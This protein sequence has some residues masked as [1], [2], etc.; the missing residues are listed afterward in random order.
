MQELALHLLDIVQNSI[1][2]GASHIRIRVEEKITLNEMILCV[3][4][5]GSGIDEEIKPHL[6]NPFTTTR[7]LRK[8]GL[9]LPF[10][11]QMCRETEGNL[12]IESKKGEGTTVTAT[13]T[14]QHIDRLPLGAV[15]KT[16]GMLILGRPDIRYTYQHIYE[17]TCFECD[18]DA[19]KAVLGD[20]PIND[21][22]II[23]W[24]E[25]FIREGIESLYCQ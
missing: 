23:A 4:D 5:N 3:E 6:T 10:L 20:V 25:S 15:E 21:L 8:V 13:M 19:L 18:T 17:E 1:R 7:T 12:R 9:G 24:I 11:E 16:I 22:E 2:A 14:Y